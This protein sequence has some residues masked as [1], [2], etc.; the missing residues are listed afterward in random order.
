MPDVEP[1]NK[2]IAVAGA[3]PTLATISCGES[4]CHTADRSAVVK[5]GGEKYRVKVRTPSRLAPGSSAPIKVVL[6]KPVREALAKG[7]TGIVR[8]TLTVVDSAGNSV[9]E[10]IRVRIKPKR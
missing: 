9:T 10:T 6:P 8:I 1:P 7:K 4:A 2:P 5:I 3:S